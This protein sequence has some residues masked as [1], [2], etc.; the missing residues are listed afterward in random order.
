[1]AEPTDPSE[2]LPPDDA[3]PP[4]AATEAERLRRFN[5]S[6]QDSAWRAI[7]YLLSGPLIY[8][9]LGALADHWLGTS[10]LVGV[11]IVGGM[12]L[13]LYLIWFRYGTH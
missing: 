1:M 10:W 7:A 13:S 11:G 5:T 2:P 4:D 3:S 8:G 9:G 12:A 6:E